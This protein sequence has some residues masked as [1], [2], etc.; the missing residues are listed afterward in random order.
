V[1]S[2][3]WF[4]SCALAVYGSMVVEAA[5]ARSN[6]Q[7]QLA[8]GG[9]EAAGD[10]YKLMRFAYPLSFAAML[11]EGAQRGTPTVGLAVAGSTLFAAAKALKWWA[12]LTLGPFWTFRVIVVP[13]AALVA[14]GPYRWFRHP[15]YVA[16]VGE[17]VAVALATGAFW[18]GAAAM[19]GFGLL[20]AKRIA[21]EEKALEAARRPQPTSK[22]KYT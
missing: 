13:G 3:I 6:E 8:R 14:I 10:V 19:T 17:L 21:V 7:A 20:L 1:S 18:S 11:A 2:A 15:N 12:I 9:V 4:L 16:V 5:R 22:G